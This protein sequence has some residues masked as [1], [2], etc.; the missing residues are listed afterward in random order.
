MDLARGAVERPG[1]ILEQIGPIEL[2]L[3]SYIR[4]IDPDGTR[5]FEDVRREVRAQA[6]RYFN[7]VVDPLSARGRAE[8]AQHGVVAALDIYA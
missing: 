5:P 8:A 2:P 6:W 4:S 7:V 1:T 3:Q